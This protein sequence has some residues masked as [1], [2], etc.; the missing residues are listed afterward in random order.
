M[1]E[2][3]G[4]SADQFE[5]RNKGI[6]RNDLIIDPGTKSVGGNSQKSQECKGKTGSGTGGTGHEVTFTAG[7]QHWWNSTSLNKK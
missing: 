6:D 3:E 7:A 4:L 5:R 1:P 2:A